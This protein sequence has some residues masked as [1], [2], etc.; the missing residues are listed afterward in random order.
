MNAKLS[1]F[2]LELE[3]AFRGLGVIAYWTK[4]ADPDDG[5]LIDVLR[6]LGAPEDQVVAI[7]RWAYDR[8]YDLFG[9][10]WSFLIDVR[11]ASDVQPGACYAEE[12]RLRRHFADDG[13]G[14]RLFQFLVEAPVSLDRSEALHWIDLQGLG[15]AIRTKSRVPNRSFSLPGMGHGSFGSS[16]ALCT[17]FD[18]DVQIV[19]SD[20]VGAANTHYSLAA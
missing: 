19:L 8:A 20:C 3:M 14:D 12:Y 4:V 9:L 13:F 10:D 16:T 5:T 18:L 1:A 2:P 7:D 17:S 11:G 6:V 15:T